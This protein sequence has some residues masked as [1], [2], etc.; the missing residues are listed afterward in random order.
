MM[1]N[2]LKTIATPVPL[3]VAQCNVLLR[4]SGLLIIYY[5][6]AAERAI[7]VAGL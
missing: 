6:A 5:G 1:S 2:D 7:L 3:S 4:P